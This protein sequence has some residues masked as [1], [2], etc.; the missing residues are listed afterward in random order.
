M[1]NN[2]AGPAR[3]RVPDCPAVPKVQHGPSAPGRQWRDCDPLQLLSLYGCLARSGQ[4]CLAQLGRIGSD[5]H[6]YAEMYQEILLASYE[7]CDALARKLPLSHSQD[8]IE[9]IHWTGE[10]RAGVSR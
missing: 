6:V 4:Q 2:D 7:V 9:Y 8:G 10:L 3:T 1:P 5:S